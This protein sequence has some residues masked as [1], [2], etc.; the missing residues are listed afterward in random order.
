MTQDQNDRDALFESQ[1]SAVERVDPEVAA[2]IRAEKLRQEQ[3]IVLIASENIAS[4]AVMAAQGT[5]LTNKYAEGYPGRRYYGGCEHVDTCERL[6]RNRAKEL[7][8]AEAANVQPHSGTSAN[9]AVYASFMKPGDKILSMSLDHG[10]HLSHGHKVNFTGKQYEIV[11]YGV[12]KDSG[13]LNYDAI[14]AQAMA[15]KPEIIVCGASAYSRIIDFERFGQ[16]AQKCGARLLADIAHISGLVATGLHPSPFPHADYVTTT[17]HKTLRGPRGGLIL[18]KKKYRKAINREVFPGMQGGP[19][20]HVI[21][22]KAVA[23]KEAQSPDFKAYQERIVKTAK[24][25][26]EALQERG[27]EIVSGGTDN[28]VFL[29]D[30]R[31]KDTT[32]KEAETILGQVGIVTNMNMIPYDPRK[33]MDPSGIRIGTPTVAS[34]NMDEAAMVRLAALMDESLQARNDE[35]GLKKVAEKTLELAKEFPIQGRYVGLFG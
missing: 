1:V 2:A 32:G 22:A 7:F 5:L 15:E 3:D 17:T 26:A 4:D 14:E 19:L 9:L 10:G 18:C 35:A 11:S 21:A 16:I 34:R 13:R 24:A 6:A 30:L 33:P 20:E 12:D 23:F 29:V 25:L 31:S 27:F 28:H 8:Q